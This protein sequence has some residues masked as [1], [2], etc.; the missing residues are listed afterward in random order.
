MASEPQEW[1]DAH[2]WRM[3][4]KIA[5]LSWE[6]RHSISVGGLAA[7]VSDL[8]AALQQRGHEVHVFT[9]LDANQCRYDCF[10]GVHYHRCPF[11]PLHDRFGY[12]E[13]MCDSFVSRLIEAEAFYDRPFDIVHGHDW[14]SVRALIHA[15]KALGR[16]TVLTLHSTEFGR[17]GNQLCDG[18]SRRIRDIEWEGTYVADHVVS[19]SC[20]LLD[21]LCW[22]YSPP[23]NK[24]SVIYN[25][26][27]VGRF[28]GDV[29]M[30][31]V[32]RNYHINEYDPMI[33]F[34]GRLAWQKGPDLLTGAMPGLL[35]YYPDAKFV[36][37][38]DGDMRASLESNS[39]TSGVGGSTRFL[40]PRTGRELVELFRTSDIVCVP[41]RNEPFGIVILEAWSAKKPV[42]VTR[43]G[44]PAEF[45]R[46][47]ETGFVVSDNQDSIGW[48][49][50]TALAN[51]EDADQMGQNGRH[52]AENRFSWND[53]ACSTE[54]IYASVS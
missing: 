30:P 25:G 26:V 52:L 51:R 38:G 48:G 33:L 14:L 44:G 16:P 1:A 42:V 20:A 23:A 46:H 6:S 17:C 31:G 41:S 36:F 8:A 18:D 3:A 21:E 34:V 13:R 43:R 11:E 4:V 2:L 45:V 10:E 22:L 49:I 12:V 39:W 35:S 54:E 15:K 32:R 24:T 5:L 28:D 29:D 9:R 27:D 19:V 7:H 47:G 40:G 53:I 37:V 50:G